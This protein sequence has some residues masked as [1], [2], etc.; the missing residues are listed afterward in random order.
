MPL[1]PDTCNSIRR[2]IIRWIRLPSCMV[3]S[4]SLPP[5]VD[6]AT[7]QDELLPRLRTDIL[8]SPR[9]VTSP[10]LNKFL[11]DNPLLVPG[12]ASRSP[13]SATGIS[14]PTFSYA[15]SLMSKPW[16]KDLCP[17]HDYQPRNS[18]HLYLESNDILLRNTDLSCLACNRIPFPALR[19]Y[20]CSRHRDT[21]NGFVKSNPYTPRNDLASITYLL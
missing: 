8:T 21:D 9:H 13:Y 17:W 4:G 20:H 16:M 15:S 1:L 12:C 6:V 18:T 2:W 10:P 3:F 14:I 5:V 7:A 11:Y 19:I